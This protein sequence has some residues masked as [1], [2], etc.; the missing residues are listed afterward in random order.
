MSP[1]R[2]EAEHHIH[3]P[4]LH[5]SRFL[6]AREQA[7]KC[8]EAVGHECIDGFIIMCVCA[9]LL[10]TIQRI[11]SLY[12][13]YGKAATFR[14]NQRPDDYRIRRQVRDRSGAEQI[15][16]KRREQELTRRTEKEKEGET[17]ENLRKLETIERAKDKRKTYKE[18]ATATERNTACAKIL[19]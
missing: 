19:G 18:Q 14:M 12:G 8:T 13:E 4:L 3:T 15:T 2:D 1:S 6:D 7:T 11:S 17:R 9:L 16:E 10:S 5:F